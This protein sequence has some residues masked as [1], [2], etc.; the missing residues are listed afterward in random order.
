MVPHQGESRRPPQPPGGPT[1][2]PGR[3]QAVY[4]WGRTGWPERRGATPT[5]KIGWS[6]GVEEIS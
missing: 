4:M 3:R 6:A 5:G 1:Q 2:D